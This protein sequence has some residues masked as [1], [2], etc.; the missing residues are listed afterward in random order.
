MNKPHIQIT[1]RVGR[2]P[3]S[4][5]KARI[6]RQEIEVSDGAELNFE[7]VYSVSDS[8]AD[9]LFAV[10][11]EK[12]GPDGFADNLKVSGLENHVREVVLRTIARRCESLCGCE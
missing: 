6:I 8:F 11:V 1:E 7:N 2:C 5:E 9:E 4:R 3:S 10:L 12:H